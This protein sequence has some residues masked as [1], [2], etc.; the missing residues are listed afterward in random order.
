ML[1]KIP[2]SR[3]GRNL[4]CQIRRNV[5]PRSTCS[6]PEA[7]QS[8]ESVVEIKENEG[9]DQEDNGEGRSEPPIKQFTHLRFYEHRDHHVS[10]SS[11][12]GRGDKESERK[13]EDEQRTCG[14]TW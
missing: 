14:N 13:N 7:I 6:T 1:R 2:I 12:Q 11:Q 4:T 9:C 5:V 3:K 8:Q 10:S